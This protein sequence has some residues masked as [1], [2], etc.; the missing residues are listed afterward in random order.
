MLESSDFS[1][2][3]CIVL[4]IKLFTVF[5]SFTD[6]VVTK[7]NLLEFSLLFELVAVVS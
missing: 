2:I 4:E 5:N 7:K 1:I 6:A 3:T